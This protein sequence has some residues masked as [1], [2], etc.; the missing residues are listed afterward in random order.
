MYSQICDKKILNRKF[1]HLQY[2]TRLTHKHVK[3]IAITH[4]VSFTLEAIRKTNHEEKLLYLQAIYIQVNVL[5]YNYCIIDYKI[6]KD[7]FS[8]CMK[9]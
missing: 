6:L 9:H 8:L 4:T 2:I 3:L 7:F 1:V 5:V